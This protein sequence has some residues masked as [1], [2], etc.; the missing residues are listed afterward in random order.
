MYSTYSWSVHICIMCTCI[1]DDGGGVMKSTDGTHAVLHCKK[2]WIKIHFNLLIFLSH[3]AVTDGKHGKLKWNFMIIRMV[4]YIHTYI[5]TLP[6]VVPRL[7]TPPPS[8]RYPF[9]FY[10][11]TMRFPCSGCG[12]LLTASQPRPNRRWW[13]RCCTYCMYTCT[14]R[15]EDKRIIN[16][17]VYTCTLWSTWHALTTV[18]ARWGLK[19]Q[20]VVHDYSVE[21]IFNIFLLLFH[22]W[23]FVQCYTYLSGK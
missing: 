8:P 21:I 10:L 7:I 11:R 22:V 23:T 20:V 9:L 3:I 4:Y 12:R 14:W 17:D 2:K 1:D 19:I 18:M 16:P 13:P 5:H 6:P 15:F